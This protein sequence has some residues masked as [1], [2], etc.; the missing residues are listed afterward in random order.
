MAAL[1]VLTVAIVQYV[2]VSISFIMI[3]V[4][5]GFSWKK[6]KRWTTEDS[7]MVGALCCLVGL[8]YSAHTTGGGGTN[9]VAHPERLTADQIRKREDASKTAV[10]ARF[11]YATAYVCGSISPHHP[12]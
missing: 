1:S 2:L 6:Q 3:V 5:I 10:V 4:R 9:N 8:L 11:S 7:W 12:E